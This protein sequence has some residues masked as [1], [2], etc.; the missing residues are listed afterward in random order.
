MIISF[1]VG[2]AQEA[3]A[4]F[5]IPR[6]S[7]HDNVHAV[8]LAICVEAGKRS[9]FFRLLGEILDGE[10]EPTDFHTS[11]TILICR[12]NRKAWEKLEL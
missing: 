3:L 11:T 7:I 10:D 12:V 2:L 4:L 1:L 9:I 8:K 6:T 5:V